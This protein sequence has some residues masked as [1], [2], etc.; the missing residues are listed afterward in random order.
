[1]MTSLIELSLNPAGDTE[2]FSDS[3]WL[4]AL[5]RFEAGLA[6]AQAAA[7]LIPAA[8]ATAIAQACARAKLDRTRFIEQARRTGAFGIG[9]V[10]PIK[11]VLAEHAPDAL[12]YLHWGTTT[13]D[14]VDTAHALLT[15]AAL[16]AVLQ[17][18]DGLDAALRTLARTHAA[19]PMMARSLLQPAQVTSF[20]LK[21]AQSAAAVRR[22]AGQLRTLAPHALCVQ[23][24]GAVGNRAA[25]ADQAAQVED[26]LAAELGLWACGHSWHTQRDAWM[27]LA[28]EAAVCA[29]SLA[30]LARDWSLMSQFE[31]GELAEAPRGRTSSAMPHKRNPVHCMQAVAQTQPVPGLASTLLACMTQAHERALG[32]WQAELSA[33]APLWRHVHAAAA[34]LRLAAEGLQVDTARMQAHIDALHQVIFSE[35]CADALAS[36]AGRDAAQ[37]AIERLAPQALAQ[38]QP[39]SI[40]LQR[41]IEETRGPEQ[42]RLAAQVLAQATDPQRAVQA[43]AACCAALLRTLD[44]PPQPPSTLEPHHV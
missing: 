28:M 39:L 7:G 1:M 17:E 44:T 11:A 37:Q 27:R 16:A 43:S 3:Q 35:A 38:R 24:G 42:A 36:L 20:G 2:L 26:T 8:A 25:M 19:T 4:Q 5:L 31:V 18:L 9:L 29:G 15:Q 21:C 32:E 12:P 40:L 23:L 34:A 10:D 6:S 14:A 30:K 13:Q 22:S 41:W 33:W